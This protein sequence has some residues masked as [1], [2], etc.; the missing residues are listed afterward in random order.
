[1]GERNRQKRRSLPGTSRKQRFTGVLCR[2]V[3]SLPIERVYVHVLHTYTG[4]ELEERTRGFIPGRKIVEG[5]IFVIIN[6]YLIFLTLLNLILLK[7]N[8]YGCTFI[9][10]KKFSTRILDYWSTVGHNFN[11]F[12]GRTNS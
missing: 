8:K 12:P 3:Y 5:V 11:V 4:V 10:R 7:V 1:M 6:N 9:I 2:Y